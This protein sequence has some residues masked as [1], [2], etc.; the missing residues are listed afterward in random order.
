MIRIESRTVMVGGGTRYRLSNGWSIHRAHHR[1]HYTHGHKYGLYLPGGHPD[2]CAATIGWGDTLR[3]V[4]TLAD[5][6]QKAANANL[7][8]MAYGKEH[9]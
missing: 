7:I 5:A 2:G 3:E 9:S 4:L 6:R 1:S 8:R